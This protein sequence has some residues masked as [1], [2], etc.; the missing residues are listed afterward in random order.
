MRRNSL[1]GLTDAQWERLRPLI[2]PQKPATGRPAKDHRTVIEGILWQLSTGAPW[3]DVPERFGPWQTVYSRLRR[4]QQAGVW[5]RIL[6]ALTAEGALDQP[7]I[8][9]GTMVRA[10]STAPALKPE[11]VAKPSAAVRPVS[12][13]RSNSGSSGSASRWSTL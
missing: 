6:A 5:D 12:P 4:W 9:D 2:P 10:L 7:S 1:T 3:R 8:V 13:S 11:P